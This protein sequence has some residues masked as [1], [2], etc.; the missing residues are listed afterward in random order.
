MQIT[1]S[2]DGVLAKYAGRIEAM[3]D[4][5]PQVLREG[6][7]EGG[8][9]IRTDWRRALKDQTA[10][11]RYGAIVGRTSGSLRGPLTYTLSAFGKLPIQEF[12]WSASKRASVR[13]SPREHW[14]LQVPRQAHG[15]FGKMPKMDDAGGVTASPWGVAHRFKRSFLSEKGPMA[16]RSAGSR[17]RRALYGPSPGKEAVKDQ[18]LVAFENGVRVHVVAMIDK[19]LA[20]LLP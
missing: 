20:R 5:V 9:R 18:A 14:R 4:K 17:A 1:V 2:L 16:I 13:W 11:K 10:V 7:G 19:R 8:N 12:R 6:L 3:G 15:R